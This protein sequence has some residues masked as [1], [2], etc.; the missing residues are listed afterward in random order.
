LYFFIK[1]FLDFF[2]AILILLLTIPLNILIIIIIYISEGKPI[3][4]KQ[5]RAGL[6]GAPFFIYKYRSMNNKLGIDGKL[7]PD[8]KRLTPLGN[9]LRKS[10]LDELPNLINVIQGKMSIVGPRPLPLKYVPL[11]SD[12]QK[13]RHLL[14][15]GITGLAQ[16]NGRNLLLWEEK[17]ELDV[18]YVEKISFFLDLNILFRTLSITINKKGISSATS[19]T[20]EEFKGNSKN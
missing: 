18:C 17:L 19:A 9:F 7:L 12:R 11:Y 16:V 5:K 13:M 15:P 20:M 3:F 10:S 6:Y 1:S 2:L 14:K 4:F 8:E